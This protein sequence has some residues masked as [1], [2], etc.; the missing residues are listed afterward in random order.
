MLLT[1][2]IVGLLSSGA[3]AQESLGSY[4]VDI[5]ET[6]VSGLSSGG[7]FAVQMQVAFSSFIKGAGIVAAG[8]YNCAGD[9]LYVNCM[10][11]MTPV[12]TS[13]VQ[14]TI[15]W[16]GSTIDDVANMKK[17]K[18]YIISGSKD[19]TVGTTVVNQLYAYYTTTGKFVDDANVVYN[20]ALPS[21]HTFPTDFDSTG[22]NACGTGASPY[23]SNCGFDGAGAILNHIYG[24]NLKPRAAFN[25]TRGA[26][27]ARAG[28]FIQFKQS[29][30]ITNPRTYGMDLNGYV[31]VP[32]ACEKGAACRLHI[33][34]HGCLQSV[35]NIQLKYV[36][37]TGFDKWADTNNIIV[38]YPQ[39]YP[40]NALHTTPANSMMANGNACWDWLG[41]YGA[42]FQVKTG[43]QMAA[44]KK[45]IDR[46][47]AGHQPG[48]EAPGA[49]E[50]PEQC[51]IVCT[52]GN[53]VYKK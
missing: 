3:L 25:H 12:L 23:V 43:T 8:P 49:P 50:E 36:Q 31:Y 34:L 1:L 42:N 15:K 10:Y 2:A 51:S 4:N 47:V 53:V 18:V 26:V 13:S 7:F 24:G 20:K 45:M 19:A 38:L 44:I 14:N 29:D 28:R 16:S 5:K 39:T 17:Q 6:S 48:G 33:A 27:N 21:A 37:N 52:R 46:I 22:N 32:E 40:D 41:W 30:F 11:S 35:Q 9:K